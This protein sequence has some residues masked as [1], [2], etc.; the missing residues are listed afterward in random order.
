MDRSNVSSNYKETH[1]RQS[2]V[3]NTGGNNVNRSFINTGMASD[4]MGYGDDL[5]K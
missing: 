1:L 3:F 5:R 2:Y 4:S